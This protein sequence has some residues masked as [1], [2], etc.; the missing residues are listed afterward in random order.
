MKKIQN[1]VIAI[2]IA[3][4]LV[5]CG[6]SSVEVSKEM[7][8]FMEKIEATN[9]IIDA[10]EAYGYEEE[11]IPLDLYTL[12]SPSVKEVKEEKGETVYTMNV[13]HGIIDSNVK[14][15]WKDGKVVNIED[16]PFE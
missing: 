8:G 6:G 10:A 13:K 11:Q 16:I 3:I 12:E 5:A 15:F 9:S 1:G 2:V 14:V 4:S 7:K